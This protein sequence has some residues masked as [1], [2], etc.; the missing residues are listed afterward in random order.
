[1]T[2]GIGAWPSPLFALLNFSH[3]PVERPLPFVNLTHDSRVF[4]LKFQPHFRR[5]VHRASRLTQ[6]AGV[7]FVGYDE[8]T[9][10]S[11]A[12]QFDGQTPQNR[13]ERSVFPRCRKL[14]L[15]KN[16]LDEVIDVAFDVKLGDVASRFSR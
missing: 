14:S 16:R 1:M 5:C 15:G 10:G 8:K 4:D 11:V 2:G 3:A 9:A 13:F 7:I 6:T 12:P